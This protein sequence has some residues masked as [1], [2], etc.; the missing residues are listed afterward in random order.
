[1]TL[2]FT[3][4]FYALEKYENKGRLPFISSSVLDTFTAP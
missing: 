2:V 3:P 1:L 4:K